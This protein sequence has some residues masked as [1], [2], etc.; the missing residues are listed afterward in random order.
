M[1][2]LLLRYLL[3][4]RSVWNQ[5]V[6]PRITSTIRVQTSIRDEI[7]TYVLRKNYIESKHG[8]MTK[9]DSRDRLKLHIKVDG[10][11][12]PG[13]SAETRTGEN[14]EKISQAGGDTDCHQKRQKKKQRQGKK[15]PAGWNKYGITKGTTV[16][17]TNTATVVQTENLANLS[18]D[19]RKRKRRREQKEQEEKEELKKTIRPINNYNEKKD[20]NKDVLDSFWERIVPAPKDVVAAAAQR[21]NDGDK[22]RNARTSDPGHIDKVEEFSEPIG[23]NVTTLERSDKEKTKI[24][25]TT[26][27]TNQGYDSGSTNNVIDTKEKIDSEVKNNEVLPREPNNSKVNVYGYHNKSN[28]TK[29]CGDKTFNGGKSSNRENT[30]SIIF[31]EEQVK[32]HESTLRAWRQRRD[33]VLVEKENALAKKRDLMDLRSSLIERQ[34]GLEAARTKHLALQVE[35]KESLAMS[36]ERLKQLTMLEREGEVVRDGLKDTKMEMTDLASSDNLRENP[37]NE[38]SDENLGEGQNAVKSNN[39]KNASF[40]DQDEPLFPLLF[41]SYQTVNDLSR[42]HTEGIGCNPSLSGFLPYL[43]ATQVG[44]YLNIMLR[45]TY[46]LDH[47]SGITDKDNDRERSFRRKLLQNTCLDV[48]LLVPPE[49]ND[50]RNFGTAAYSNSTPHLFDPNISLCP[51]E[52]QGIC[53]DEFCP[54]QHTTKATRF[55]ARERLPLPSLTPFLSAGPLVEPRLKSKEKPNRAPEKKGSI[56]KVNAEMEQPNHN[57]CVPLHVQETKSANHG[58]KTS[59]EEDFI[60]LPPYSPQNFEDESNDDDD[61]DSV[62]S[63]DCDSPEVSGNELALP[64]SRPSARGILSKHPRKISTFWWGGKL[65]IYQDERSDELV[66]K[67]TKITAFSILDILKDTYGLVLHEYP[68]M[69]MAGKKDVS[70]N[71][72]KRLEIRSTLSPDPKNADDIRFTDEHKILGRLLDAIRMIL[73][74]GLHDMAITIS[75][76]L[77][78]E[79]LLKDE[80]V[81]SFVSLLLD[82]TEIPWIFEKAAP[83][84]SCFEATFATQI[85]LSILSLSIAGYGNAEEGRKGYDHHSLHDLNVAFKSCLRILK[86]P[87]RNTNNAFEAFETTE[88]KKFLENKCFNDNDIES[89]P[90]Q[91]D[92]ACNN[93]CNVAM[94][95]ATGKIDYLISLILRAQKNLIPYH[96]ELDATDEPLEERLSSIWLVAKN[97]L[98]EY[99]ETKLQ[100]AKEREVD[101]PQAQIDESLEWEFQC[102]KVVILMGYTIIGC[103]K[104]LARAAATVL[105]EPD[106]GDEELLGS[107]LPNT[108]SNTAA[109]TL[110]DGAIARVLKEMRRCLVGFPLLDVT[111]APLWASSVAS[112]TYL[113][114][115]SMAQNR[116]TD[117]LKGQY[118]RLDNAE[119]HA[120]TN[121]MAFSEL[122][123]SQL[124]QLRMSLP[125]ES[126]NSIKALSILAKSN[127][128]LQTNKDSGKHFPWEFSKSLKEENRRLVAKLKSLNIRLCHVVLWGDWMLS[129]AVGETSS[130]T[131]LRSYCKNPNGTSQGSKK[132]DNSAQSSVSIVWKNDLLKLR[133]QSFGGYRYP[134]PSPLPSLPLIL[135]HAGKFLTHLDLKGCFLEKL[136]LAFGLSFPNLRT[137]D[138]SGNRLRELP[139]SLRRVTHRMKFLEEFCARNNCL[140]SLPS[141]TLLSSSSS[142][143]SS[144]LRILALSH[145]KLG[146]VPSLVGLHQ[147]EVLE[148]HHNALMDMTMA[149]WSRLALRLPSLRILECEHQC[150]RIRYDKHQN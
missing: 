56:Q 13:A 134:Q 78:G 16:A 2:Q 81:R 23:A 39:S 129:N 92:R 87:E 60:M 110:L 50:C 116:L 122:L 132:N 8:N 54:Y 127:K 44:D 4:T 128:L 143:Q 28:S 9:C 98:K 6:I 3:I 141:D 47:D 77:L 125:N 84:L 94:H 91:R 137:L 65:P 88:L 20:S 76:E 46:A 82:Q 30:I 55:L 19:S 112:A 83:T 126:P 106:A 136:P 21:I 93:V 103:L 45:E 29:Q 40:L 59:D 89:F 36:R 25:P 22:P 100:N 96:D 42:H 99:R 140:A 117:C 79:T 146:S 130:K 85:G 147:L 63:E 68:N 72:V 118:H 144:P 145:N 139:E 75:Q 38:E 61:G 18:K 27:K 52:L 48:L 57:Q 74:G 66:P 124:V 12:A 138:L 104:N 26:N 53:T 67:E 97:F 64:H 10:A 58:G 86:N 37:E 17:R 123:W 71:T 148:L 105:V 120:L 31:L 95:N 107:E 15:C 142:K 135:L 115:Y 49:K 109:W 33:A 32:I 7:G 101:S 5:S 14:N 80:S 1:I 121:V 108:T 114:S 69:T 119:D 70:S 62:N 35:L 90:V 113:R 133:E 41:D 43:D 24:T 11:A 102:L 111:L 150:L 131:L 34:T 149:D 51:Y 73:H